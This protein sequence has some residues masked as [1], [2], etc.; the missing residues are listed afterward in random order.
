MS[1]CTHITDERML[2]MIAYI[3]LR[4]FTNGQRKIELKIIKKNSG[5]FSSKLR[6]REIT[7]GVNRTMDQ[8][9]ISNIS[10]LMGGRRLTETIS[11]STRMQYYYPKTRPS[12][13]HKPSGFSPFGFRVQNPFCTIGFVQLD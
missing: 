7:A 4:I 1:G 2:E 12:F 10:N 6:L 9:P 13:R 3:H 5:Q 8:A 11:N